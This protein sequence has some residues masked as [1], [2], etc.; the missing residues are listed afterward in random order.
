[1][2]HGLVGLWEWGFLGPNVGD[3][4]GAVSWG[5]AETTRRLFSGES[6][7]TTPSQVSCCLGLKGHGAG[8]EWVRV[9]LVGVLTVA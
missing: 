9:T 3:P 6:A 5:L 7:P 2:D 8:R 1:M 4:H